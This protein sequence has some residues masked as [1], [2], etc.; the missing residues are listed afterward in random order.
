MREESRYHY[1]NCLV[2]IAKIKIERANQE[3]KWQSGD[4]SRMMRDFSSYKELYSQKITQQEQL[5]KQL[6]RQQKELK[7]TAGVMTNQK[8][9]FR[10]LLQLLDAKMVSLGEGNLSPGKAPSKSDAMSFE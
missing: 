5:T 6:R 2:S 10:Q 8:S 9:S 3:K 4:G 1:L 7:E